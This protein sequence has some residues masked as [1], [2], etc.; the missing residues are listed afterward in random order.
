MYPNKIFIKLKKD[1]NW[2]PLKKDTW[3]ISTMEF[4]SVIKKFEIMLFAGK[5]M[6]LEYFKLIEVSQP[7]NVKG[8]MFS[9][10]CE[11]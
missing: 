3:Y 10:T 4:Y 7:Q 9:H 11:S 5:W 8:H 1:I 6:E 2:K